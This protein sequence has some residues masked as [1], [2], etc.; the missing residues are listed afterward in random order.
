LTILLIFTV[1][2]ISFYIL[3]YIDN[4]YILPLSLLIYLISCFCFAFNGFS[5]AQIIYFAFFSFTLYLS[6]KLLSSFFIFKFSLNE[7]D[8][9]FVIQNFILWY[10]YFIL[11]YSYFFTHSFNHL[12]ESFYFLKFSSIFCALYNYTR[13]NTS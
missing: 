1:I 11:S 4:N 9:I 3:V 7:I 13:F 6:F 5:N 12:I 2:I 10:F 8:F